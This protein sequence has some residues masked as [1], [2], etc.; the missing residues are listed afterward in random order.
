MIG[1]FE[2]LKEFN[3]LTEDQPD[4]VSSCREVWK[5]PWRCGSSGPNKGEGHQSG[6]RLVDNWHAGTCPGQSEMESNI[7]ELDKM[8]QL[9]WAKINS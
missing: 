4:N 1:W 9:F 5:A 7:R 3:I 6:I 8:N 2:S